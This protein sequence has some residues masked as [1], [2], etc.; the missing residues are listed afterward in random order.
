[1]FKNLGHSHY[2]LHVL[3]VGPLLAYI[4]HNKTET[5]EKYYHYLTMVS[6]MIL[7]MIRFP[8]K[9]EINYWNMIKL[10]HY[11]GWLPLLLYVANKGNKN[12]EMVYKIL[13]VLGISAMS[14]NGYKL[15][16]LI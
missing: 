10:V 5:P 16:N 15:I 14:Y 8:T 2:F 3:I 7:F 9:F 6:I 11:L 13:L 1:M 4:G 12:S